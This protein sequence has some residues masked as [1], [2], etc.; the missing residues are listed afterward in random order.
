MIILQNTAL[1][2]DEKSKSNKFEMFPFWALIMSKTVIVTVHGQKYSSP[3]IFY[4]IFHIKPYF[5]K[6]IF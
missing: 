5:F 3:S 2:L 1:K 4:Y 6:K